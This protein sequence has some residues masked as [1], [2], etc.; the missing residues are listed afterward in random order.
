MIHQYSTDTNRYDTG[1]HFDYFVRA[2][3]NSESVDEDD[4]D[5]DVMYFKC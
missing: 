4:N 2:F 3:D 5:N 1:E